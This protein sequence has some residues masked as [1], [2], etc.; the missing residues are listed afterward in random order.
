MLDAT[1]FF[2][3]EDLTT[4]ADHFLRGNVDDFGHF[5]GRLRVYDKEYD[6]VAIAPPE[7]VG[8]K[9]ECGPFEVV[10]GYLMRERS[11]SLIVGDDYKDLNEKLEKIGGLYVYRDGIRS[12]AVR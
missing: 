9:T 8:I 3:K 2:T 5:G 4:R 6:G 10:F 7:E 12:A 1:T 11:E